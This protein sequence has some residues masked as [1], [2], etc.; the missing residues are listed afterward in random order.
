M[1]ANTYR[2]KVGVKNLKGFPEEDPLRAMK[3]E[4]VKSYQFLF[5]F[6]R[7]VGETTYRNIDVT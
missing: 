4:E 7:V 2:G 3:L 1:S 5:W 6:F